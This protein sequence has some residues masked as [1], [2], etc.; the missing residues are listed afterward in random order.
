MR[1]RI[2]YLVY[3]ILI[4]AF[5]TAVIYYMYNKDLVL[6]YINRAFSDS[7]NT[8]STWCVTSRPCTYSDVVDLR[9]IVITF[10]RADSLSKLLHS[11]DTLVL[12]G[13]RASLE[14]P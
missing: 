10:N 3:C 8:N 11:V 5:V 1:K 9:I 13:D 6:Q 2:A 14:I 12:D 4:A 7:N